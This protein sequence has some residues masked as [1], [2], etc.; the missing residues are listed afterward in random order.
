MDEGVRG[1]AIEVED[2]PLD[3]FMASSLWG[4]ER[5]EVLRP[6]GGGGSDVV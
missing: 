3:Y 1:A 4:R 6:G 2:D 5:E